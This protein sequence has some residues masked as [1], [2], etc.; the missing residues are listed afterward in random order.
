MSIEVDGIKVA[1]FGGRQGPRGPVGPQG[2]RGEQGPTGEQGPE[3]PQGI[4]GPA[5]PQGETGA[6]GPQGPPGKDG[7]GVPAGG[8]AG[9]MLIKASGADGDVEWADPPEG[10]VT[11]FNGR[12]GAVMPQS[13]DYTAEMVG[14]RPSDWVP[15][16]QEV[17]A[18]SST[19]LQ[20]IQIMT[21]GEYSALEEKSN[22]TLYLIEE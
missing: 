4:Q 18:V 2:E 10:G 13:G 12:M 3:G 6:A 16:A 5:G 19:E 7:E 17:G 22:G 14:A 8:E 11:S 9:Q 20:N 21:E 1:G 15:T